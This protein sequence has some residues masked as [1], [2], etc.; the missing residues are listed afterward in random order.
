MDTDTPYSSS[1]QIELSKS[2][3][4]QEFKLTSDTISLRLHQ[5]ANVRLLNVMPSP[6]TYKKTFLKVLKTFLY[7]RGLD[8]PE[9]SCCQRVD[10][11]IC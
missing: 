10:P 6:W 4:G 7:V 5:L 3:C 2:K 9:H 11:P 8:V 1:N